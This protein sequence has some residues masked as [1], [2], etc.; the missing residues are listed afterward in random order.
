MISLVLAMSASGGP[1]SDGAHHT[2]LRWETLRTEHFRVH[3][4]VARTGGLDGSAAAQRVARE[5]EPLWA[6]MAD[7]Y[8]FHPREPLHVVL[9]AHLDG[10]EAWTI[11]RW[12][13]IALSPT[14]GPTLPRVRGATEW[15]PDALAHELGHVFAHKVSGS[16]SE[17][18]SYGVELGVLSER[19]P[20]AAGGVLT[21]D[22]PVPHAWSEG[23]AEHAAE[24][25]DVGRW[26]TSREETLRVAALGDRLLSLQE[27]GLALDKDD[28]GDAELAYQQ[29]YAWSRWLTERLG[30]PAAVSLAGAASDRLRTS[31][32]GL[33][34]RH[35]GSSAR[36]LHE[37]WLTEARARY[38]RRSDAV[39]GAELRLVADPWVSDERSAKDAWDLRRPRDRE[40]ARSDTGAWNLH[41]R[42]DPRGRWYGE[43]RQGWVRV[44][45]MEE[46]LWPAL[47]G[48]DP[49]DPSTAELRIRASREGAWLP[50]VWGE[51]F[52]FLA[53]R[54]AVVVVA[55]S[56]THRTGALGPRRSDPPQQLYVVDLAPRIRTRPHRG[57]RE[58][59][60]EL[61]VRGA[62]LRMRYEPVPG[63]LRASVPAAALDGRLAW[64]QRTD[65]GVTIRVGRPDGS[66]ART[67]WTLGLGAH[68]QGLAWAPDG[69][70][71]AVALHH[72]DQQNLWLLEVETGSPRALTWDRHEERDPTWSEHGITFTADAT[73]RFEVYELDLQTGRVLQHTQV[74]GG[75]HTPSRT[76][77][78]HLTYSQH[79]AYGY[80]AM[81]LHRADFL[82]R[83]ATADFTLRP[84]DAVVRADLAPLEV[85]PPL[86]PR[87]YA[88]HRAWLPLAAG[89]VL[90]VEVGDRVSPQ[91]GAYLRLR[92]ALERSDWAVY[93]LLGEDLFAWGRWTLRALPPALSLSAQHADDLLLTAAPHGGALRGRRVLQVASADVDQ[94]WRDGVHLLAGAD[95]VALSAGAP[96]VRPVLNSTRGRL[97]FSLGSERR[98]EPD[99]R[100][101]LEVLGTA[102]RTTVEDGS[103]P[104]GPWLRLSADL[105][106]EVE[107]APRSTRG[108]VWDLSAWGGTTTAAVHPEEELR[109]GGDHPY[110]VHAARVQRSVPFPGYAPYALSGRHL[111]VVRTGLAVP[112]APNLRLGGPGLGLRSVQA[113]LG[114]HAGDAWSEASAAVP[115]PRADG[116]AE[117]RVRAVLLGSEWDSV[118]RVSVPVVE[119]SEGAGRP[120]RVAIGLGTGW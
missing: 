103:H 26:S 55:P 80:K 8:G 105:D 120:A 66:G 51:P 38:E 14:S 49:A 96:T 90:R 69:S 97:G 81:G 87:R 43:A 41:P 18:A 71:L 11:P 100:G 92:D 15:I 2:E 110:A 98:V 75:A 95:L 56:D 54:D 99:T 13:W 28:V 70:Q 60:G 117:L 67:L 85:P 72:R 58:E 91:G 77:G 82:E 6:R 63:T 107:L 29:G 84:P 30:A 17:R 19:G 39:E 111:A 25:I 34:R 106:A 53:D 40:R 23:G 93:G 48:P 52:A 62:E 118:A 32:S 68:V 61:Q 79:T 109:A 37:A 108:V 21:L 50:A 57:T 89:P 119:V 7:L 73:G 42:H 88:A 5:A 113:W 22:P 20:V 86:T 3:Y 94:R 114:G 10:L 24:L 101:A 65:D 78:G 115:E 45:R 27:L 33:L 4:P 16:L 35:S 116:T 31:W 9:V 47:G 76:P 12:D 64:A 74:D 104:G 83:D 102:A 1:L 46:G 59:V 44:A 36:S 112:L